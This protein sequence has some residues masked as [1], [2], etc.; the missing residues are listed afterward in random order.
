M[1]AVIANCPE[2]ATPG[3]GESTSRAVIARRVHRVAHVEAQRR[4][5]RRNLE[6]LTRI[7]NRHG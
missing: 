3:C 5:D 7:Q 2:A 6:A 1:L 4:S